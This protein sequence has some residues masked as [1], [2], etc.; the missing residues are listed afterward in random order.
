MKSSPF[1][2]V[3]FNYDRSI[4]YFFYTRFMS[5]LNLNQ[6]EAANLM[7]YIYRV[8]VHGL[9]GNPHFESSDGRPYTPAMSPEMVGKLRDEGIKV[10]D[11]ATPYLKGFAWALEQIK[12]NEIICFL[13]FAYA[14]MNL[15]NLG[16]LDE[17]ATWLSH[18]RLY[19]SAYE[20]DVDLLSP[21]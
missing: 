10:A 20:L 4:E 17:N 8:H 14:E 12:A 6:V 3:T 1:R 2:I 15:R 5:R 18:K 9:L 21:T 16:L 11:E 7:K 19:G 13:G